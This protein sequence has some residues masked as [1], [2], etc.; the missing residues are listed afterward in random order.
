MKTFSSIPVLLCVA[1]ALV[2]CSA[3][4]G[5]VGE[6]VGN[7]D[8]GG[9]GN[10][11]SSG[12][13]G[14]TIPTTGGT[15][16]TSGG[17]AGTISVSG[18][19]GTAG[20][21]CGVQTF[22][23]ERKPA[24]VLLVLDR[25]ASMKDPP[26]ET[27]ETAPKWDLIIPALLEVV[28]ATGATLSWGLKVFPEDGDGEQ[29]ACSAGSVT[30][31]IDVE[32]AENN[33]TVV[34]DA[35]RATR[36]EGDG[37]PTGDA[38]KQAVTYLQGRAGLN[39]YNRYILL[40]TDGE[41]SCTN[42][43]ATS[44]GS[45]GQEAARP[46]AV[47]AVTEAANAGFHTFVVGVGTNKET[48]KLV[49]NDLAIAGQEPASCANPLDDC[50][51]LG[52]SREQLA[53]DLMSIAEGITT[54]T[55][56]LTATP[57]DPSNVRVT[58]DTERVMRDPSKTNGWE[59]EDSAATIIIVHGAACDAIKASRAANVEIIFGCPDIDVR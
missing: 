14:A 41:P 31:R 55:F 35:I 43:T 26:E 19:G 2:A 48:A 56:M 27:T 12:G 9:S 25:S 32:I 4:E 45:E 29:D 30:D 59:Y 5:P 33:A 16:S 23:L 47:N 1:G 46:Y 36:D 53:A 38:M 37:T 54:C 50:F 7:D 3:S 21:E 52:N 22:N 44:A 42:V 10:D 8:N 34:N 58:L 6:A 11:T 13:S 40:A 18:S 57:P 17:T 24:E 15:S 20:G 39:D 51:Y 49:L 28:E